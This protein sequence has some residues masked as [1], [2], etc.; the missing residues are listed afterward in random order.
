[1]PEPDARLAWQRLSPW[2]LA[3]LFI[4]GL[5]R[6]VR[7]NLPL[8]IGAGAG[9]AWLERTGAGHILFLIALIALLAALLSLLYFR[10]F[11][12]RLDGDVLLVQKGLFQRSEVKVSSARVQ[13]VSI[14]QPFY[15][16]PFDVVCL[17]IDTPGGGTGNVELPGL[18]REV[19]EHLRGALAAQ[20]EHVDSARVQ[21]GA[22]PLFRIR[23]R[24]LTLHGLASNHA[25]V[26]AAAL[27]PFMEPVVRRARRHVRA[28][29][30]HAWLA[31]AADSPLLAA[32]AVVL[33]LAAVLA[34]VS[35]LV[36]WL[37]YWGFTLVRERERMV[38]RSGL[39]NRQEQALALS[40]LQAVE[41]VQTAVGRALGCGHL[42]CRQFGPAGGSESGRSSFLIPGL[43]APQ[44]AALSAALWPGLAAEARFQRVHP[45]YRRTF[46]IRLGVLVWLAAALVSLA[47]QSTGWLLGA[48]LASTLL[49]PAAYLRWRAV[50]WQSDGAYL[51]V[52]RGLLGRRTTVFRAESVQAVHVSES[53]FQ[54]RRGLATL[55]FTLPSGPVTIPCLWRHEALWLADTTLY[56]LVSCIRSSQHF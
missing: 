27:T 6:W 51:R 53:W 44:A 40:K 25:Y 45:Y 29:D 49:W 35:V 28:I 21:A 26:L 52:R 22:A 8:L 19:A 31:T 15:M 1:M 18:K 4:N 5:L 7:E 11:R 16:R 56:R 42:I 50:G 32:A 9:L 39:F 14:E 3:I 30:E 36:S 47:S 10:R 54:R 12:F 55:V 13:H 37:R 48:L 41:W 2:A 33:A 17:R 38:Q 46:I 43:D 23:A 24:A 34:L 20:A